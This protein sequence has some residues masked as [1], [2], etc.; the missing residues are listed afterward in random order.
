MPL[1]VSLEEEEQ[2]LNVS[3]HDAK[4]LVYEMLEVMNVQ[5][6]TQD[7]SLRVPVE[8]FTEIG[9]VANHYNQVI[10]SLEASTL[11]LKQFNADLEQQEHLN[12]ISRSGEH[13]LTLR[14][15]SVQ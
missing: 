4:N 10:D 11:E 6:T 15:K 14:K 3:E 12:I 5:A 8:P 9:Y 7:L 2:G 13:L 1:R